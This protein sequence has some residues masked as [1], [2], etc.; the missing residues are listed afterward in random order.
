MPTPFNSARRLLAESCHRRPRHGLACLAGVG[1][2]LLAAQSGSASGDPSTA[3][4]DYLQRPDPSYRWEQ[5]RS[6]KLRGTKFAELLLVSQTWQDIPWKHQLFVLKPRRLKNVN[7]Q[8]LLVIDGGRWRAEYEQPRDEADLPKRALLFARLAKVLRAP[9]AVLR[10]VPHQPILGGLTEDRIIAHSFDRYL[11]SGDPDWPLLLP[12]TKSATKAMDAVQEFV[13]KEWSVPLDSFTVV[14]GSKRG[15][16]TWLVG[17]TDS[18]VKAIAPVVIDMLKLESQMA[19]QRSVWG[20]VSEK[21]SPYTNIDL[22]GRLATPGGRALQQIVDPFSYRAQ[23]TQPKLIVIG[24]NDAYW[25][26]DAL[27][28]YWSE[29]LGPKYV[30]YVP[31]DGHSIT[32]YRRLLGSVAALHRY[33]AN[34]QS[35]PEVNWRFAE[36]DQRLVL[37]LSSDIK[38]R[39]A[40]AWVA[41]APSR[42]FR[43]ANWSAQRLRRNS[44]S[45]RFEL[46]RPAEGYAA[47][48]GEAVFGKRRRAYYLSSNVRVVDHNG[49]AP[50]GGAP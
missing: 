35:L 50:A 34:A 17:A 9:V 13:A 4:V 42:D 18:R 28:L 43:Q 19:H 5:A 1:L 14:G 23:L 21:I 24:T 40:Y 27:N 38:P 39:R 6:G 20:R 30:L 37:E 16:T 11:R 44:N 29:L 32:D 25:P 26:L 2:A 46:E 22:P 36:P 45:Y 15:W 47:V 7:G 10:Q 8:A 12:M 31:N 33:T 48:F 49:S 3:L 41:Y